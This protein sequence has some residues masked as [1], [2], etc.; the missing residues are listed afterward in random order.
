MKEC[1]EGLLGYVI[2]NRAPLIRIVLIWSGAFVIAKLRVIDFSSELSLVELPNK[3]RIKEPSCD[4][5]KEEPA[6]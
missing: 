4:L 2:Q 5:G 6:N 3:L 1:L